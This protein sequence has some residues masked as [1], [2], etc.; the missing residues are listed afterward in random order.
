MNALHWPFRL[1]GIPIAEYCAEIPILRDVHVVQNNG[2]G[3]Q[4]LERECEH[5]LQQGIVEQQPVNRA[6]NDTDFVQSS[7]NG[8]EV[9]GEPAVTERP[10]GA[11][12]QQRGTFR[13]QP[14][15]PSD[16]IDEA[17]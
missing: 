4:L 13:P 9:T 12:K 14:A 16:S 1:D 17:H 10:R 7:A 6:G 3:T 15:L 11:G 8:V 5:N 2:S